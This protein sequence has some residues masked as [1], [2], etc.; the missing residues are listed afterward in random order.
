MFREVYET[1]HQA[2]EQHNQQELF[3]HSFQQHQQ[4][5]KMNTTRQEHTGPFQIYQ[6][7]VQNKS[8]QGP[9]FQVYQS[10]GANRS[11]KNKSAAQSGQS[12]DSNEGFLD[13]IWNTK[14][15]CDK[16]EVSCVVNRA[17]TSKFVIHQSSSL[18]IQ[19][20]IQPKGSAMKTPFR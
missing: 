2:N 14:V 3:Q 9:A 5:Q 11:M 12:D 8:T 7:P 17:S 16:E 18:G 15:T 6:S 1:Y 13:G 20:Q 4:E 10:P 19:P